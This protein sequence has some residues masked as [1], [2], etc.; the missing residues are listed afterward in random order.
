M[1]LILSS[2]VIPNT[3]Y[4]RN[5]LSVYIKNTQRICQMDVEKLCLHGKH[6]TSQTST[7][8]YWISSDYNRHS[9]KEWYDVPLG[10]GNDGDVC[11]R[12]VYDQYKTGVSKRLIPKCVD[13]IDK[14]EGQFDKI[15]IREKGNDRRELFVIF[16]TI[17]ATS[18]SGGLGYILGL[19]Q[20]ERDDLFSYHNRNENKKILIFFGVVTSIPVVIILWACPRLLVIM[21]ITAGIGRG[22]QY[23]IQMRDELA[24]SRVSG[25]DSGIVF[26]A[27]PLS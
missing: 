17:F 22:A 3:E 20:K 12:E 15:R 18:V 23:Y 21:M 11:L 16:S 24:Y 9:Y 4:L 14:T 25:S 7:Y 8:M 10:F 1:S 13:W 27:V 19:F 6:I 26:A 5:E 2:F